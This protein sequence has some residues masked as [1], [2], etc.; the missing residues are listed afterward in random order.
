MNSSTSLLSL[1]SKESP[2]KEVA[3]SAGTA[4]A[5][6]SSVFDRKSTAASKSLTTWSS[7]DE[8]IERASLDSAKMDSTKANSYDS[9][10][11]F[12]PSPLS[13][14]SNRRSRRNS[15]KKRKFDSLAENDAIESSKKFLYQNRS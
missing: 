11:G 9:Y 5:D 4:A 1:H 15:F 3:A 2:T 10:Q 6:D 7:F 14:A 13:P 12:N 8:H